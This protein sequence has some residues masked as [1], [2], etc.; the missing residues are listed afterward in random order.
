MLLT[1][2]REQIKDFREKVEKAQAD[3][4]YRRNET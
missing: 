2:L 3:S 4:K 1:P